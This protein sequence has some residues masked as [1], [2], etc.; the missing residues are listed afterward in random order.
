MLREFRSVAS[1]PDQ[2]GVQ[3]V[4]SRHEV[5]WLNVILSPSLSESLGFLYL[6]ALPEPPYNISPFL[7]NSAEL[8]GIRSDPMVKAVDETLFSLLLY[9][10]ASWVR[11]AL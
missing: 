3:S 9:L 7:T 6:T 8:T 10:L 11:Q 5:N 1:S 2:D 4:D